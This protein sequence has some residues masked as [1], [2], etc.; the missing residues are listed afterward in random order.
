[1]MKLVIERV[2]NERIFSDDILDVRHMCMVYVS[3]RKE[4]KYFRELSQ[5]FVNIYSDRKLLLLMQQ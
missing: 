5:T 1:M 3:D 2:Q 4:Q